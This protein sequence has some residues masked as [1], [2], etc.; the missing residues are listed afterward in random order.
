MSYTTTIDTC[1]KQGAETVAVSMWLDRI[2]LCGVTGNWGPT[3]TSGSKVLKLI[4]AQHSTKELLSKR[5]DVVSWI[6]AELIKHGVNFHLTLDD[7]AITHLTF[8]REF[9][10]DIKPKQ[11][12]S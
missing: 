1:S 7:V 3:S 6:K 11:M 12:V 5:N 4:M 8:G 2:W 9:M 10:K